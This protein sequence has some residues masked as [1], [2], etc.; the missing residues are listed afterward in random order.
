VRLRNGLYH[1]RGVRRP[2]QRC[3]ASRAGAQED[4]GVFKQA[5][6]HHIERAAIE[7]PVV[8]TTPLTTPWRVLMVPSTPGRLIET[9]YLVLNLS[10]P[11]VISDT[12]W[13]KP[14]KAAWDW[15]SGLTPV[16]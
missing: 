12:S 15:W 9:N 1:L 7:Q 14:G 3:G 16:N 10:R 11:C 2:Q 4:A 6:W 5:L 13:I 8:G